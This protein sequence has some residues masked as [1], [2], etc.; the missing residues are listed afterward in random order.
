MSDKN[1]ENKLS[2]LAT[3]VGIEFNFSTNQK[4]R[5][6]EFW[7]VEIINSETARMESFNRRR[8]GAVR[9]QNVYEVRLFEYGYGLRL[10]ILLRVKN[11]KM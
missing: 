5:N 1:E 7:L 4:W 3:P 11:L 9:K 10:G 8:R 2:T 6:T